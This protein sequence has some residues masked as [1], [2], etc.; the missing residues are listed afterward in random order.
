MYVIA[1]RWCRSMVGDAFPFT[2]ARLVGAAVVP[3]SLH[4]IRFSG[5]AS[6]EKEGE[7]ELHVEGLA[8]SGECGWRR[9]RVLLGAGPS[10]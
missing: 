6:A 1:A 9:R 3:N 10:D 2:P 4:G 8:R 5:G 7:P